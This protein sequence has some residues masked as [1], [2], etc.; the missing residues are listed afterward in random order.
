MKSRLVSLLGKGFQFRWSGNWVGT[1]HSIS[2]RVLNIFIKEL[3]PNYKKNF[4]I[5]D[6]NDQVKILKN[7]IKKLDLDINS[8]N[9][10]HLLGLVSRLKNNYIQDE[11]E[12]KWEF[13]DDNQK[14]IIYGYQFND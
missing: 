13:E 3:S 14:K 8:H 1:F 10:G 12:T 9:T 4:I 11:W 7:T 5:Y 6:R 2:N